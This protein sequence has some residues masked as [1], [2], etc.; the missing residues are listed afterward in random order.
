M[1]LYLI[2]QPCGEYVNMTPK[3]WNHWIP[4]F[5]SVPSVNQVEY[6]PYF[7]QK[8]WRS[9]LTENDLKE[10]ALGKAV[11][12]A[13]SDGIAAQTVQENVRTPFFTGICRAELFPPGIH[14]LDR[15]EY[16]GL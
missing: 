9:L 11:K 15:E 6:N 2:H 8:E 10:E 16:D 13:I 12:W 7:Q 5:D 4:Q 1:D 14:N 3:I